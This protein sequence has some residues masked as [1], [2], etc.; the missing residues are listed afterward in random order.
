MLFYDSMFSDIVLVLYCH[1]LCYSYSVVL[2]ILYCDMLWYEYVFSDIVLVLYW[3]VIC[4]MYSLVL[5]IL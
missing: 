5:C 2:Y 1:A 3:H 4:Y